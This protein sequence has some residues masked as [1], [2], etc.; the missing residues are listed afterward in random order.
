MEPL[1]KREDARRKKLKL[2]EASSLL[3]DEE[4]RFAQDPAKKLYGH[5]LF[6]FFFSP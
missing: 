1:E 3:K 5:W 6:G 4:V 2:F